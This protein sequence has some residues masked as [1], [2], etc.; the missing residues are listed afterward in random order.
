MLDNELVKIH[1]NYIP[2]GEI[3]IAIKKTFERIKRIIP[4]R[5]AYAKRRKALSKKLRMENNN[6]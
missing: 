5:L 1:L 6:G 2:A 3:E 4:L